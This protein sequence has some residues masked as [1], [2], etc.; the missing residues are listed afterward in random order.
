MNSP[1]MA[2][3]AMQAPATSRA[4]S[5]HIALGVAA[6]TAAFAILVVAA[7]SDRLLA[8]FWLF[9]LAFG[10][11]LQRSRFCFASAFRDLFLLGEARVM[12]GILA[13]LALATAGFAVLMARLLP[14][15]GYGSLPLGATVLPLGIHTLLGGVLFGVGMVLAG[16]CTSGSLYRAGEG[17]VGSMV[18]LLGIM[19]GLETSSHTW[20]WWWEAH[21]SQVPLVWLPDLL[22]GYLGGLLL[23]FGAL[24]LLYLAIS[25]W[26]FR[27]SIMLPA[28]R[29][30]DRMAS[31]F[32]EQLRALGRT[33]FVQGWP[34][35]VGGVALAILNV[36]LY[37]YRHPW[38]VVAGLGIWADKLASALDL[39]AGELL[40]R[41]SLAGCAF[42]PAT[43]SALGHMPLLNL[44]VIAG[45]FIAASLASEFKLRFPKQ[46]LRY[47]QS[48][49]GGVLMG[50]G[51]GLALGCTVG[52]FF[53]AIPSLALNGWVFAGALA[54]GAYVG[55]K[56]LN[57]LP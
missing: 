11:V 21:I 30:E 52:A 45:A 10:F 25:W 24:L 50:Y 3:I 27:T 32:G 51:A 26:E 29:G 5:L 20:N 54:I 15:V 19:L 49:G 1:D 46:P 35:V 12:K 17:Y 57:R 33:I 55:V 42:E 36:F 2:R 23:T 48:L 56:I 44:G 53:S 39:G 34:V 18:S 43:A 40:G 22:G 8:V 9:G 4:K 7:A 28:R 16:G 47:V 38:G 13:G 6:A 41:S 37:T 14:E 31:S